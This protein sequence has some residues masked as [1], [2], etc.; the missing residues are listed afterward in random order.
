[1][2]VHEMI[3]NFAI[4]MGRA[5]DLSASIIESDDRLYWLNQ[6]QLEF[7]RRRFSNSNLSFEQSQQL[8]DDLKTLVVAD[9]RITTAQAL[10]SANSNITLQGIYADKATLP[11]NCMVLLTSRSIIYSLSARQS[12]ISPNRVVLVG[13]QRTL[14]GNDVI[15]S[16]RPN[17]L[18][19]HD[20]LYQ[21]LEDPFWKPTLVA[22]IA[23]QKS[24]EL[25]VY[26]TDKFVVSS[27]KVDYIKPPREMRLDPQT[28]CELPDF[29][30][31]EIV[32]L[33]VSLFV[34]NT[35]TPQTRGGSPAGGN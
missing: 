29:V 21:M 25:H 26:S 30:H 1:M 23:I 17:R 22:P 10:D 11:S 12:V 34:A 18:A 8:K 6:A 15:I 28:D 32:S 4:H 20:Q 13:Q 2:N 33:A 9:H 24:N 19:N 31:D 14:T 5:H 7:V 3:Y 35:S 16:V 27:V